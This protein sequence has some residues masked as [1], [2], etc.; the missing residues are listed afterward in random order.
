MERRKLK[1]LYTLDTGKDAYGGRHITVVF[2]DD[3]EQRYIWCTT[4][5]TKA[6]IELVKDGLNDVTFNV[7]YVMNG[8]DIK[9][10]RLTVNH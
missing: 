5:K 3:E 4:T 1:I 7:Q 2:V 10:E 6:Y 8:G 9:I